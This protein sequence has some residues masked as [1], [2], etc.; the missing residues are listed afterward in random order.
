MK[1]QPKT[2]V[3]LT[4]NVDNFSSLN[5]SAENTSSSWSLFFVGDLSLQGQ[6]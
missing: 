3:Q 4:M 1:Q 5:L 6:N 2:C